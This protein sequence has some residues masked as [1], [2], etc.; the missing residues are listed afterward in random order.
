[1]KQKRL[2]KTYFAM[3][4]M[5]S[6]SIMPMFSEQTVQAATASKTVK[7][8]QTTLELTQGKTATLKML[9]TKSKAVFTS[10]NVKV[11]KVNKNTGRVAAKN[12][13]K[14]TITA[15]LKNG[16]KYT[17]KVTVT[18]GKVVLPTEDS[19]LIAGK[20]L[21]IT[22]DIKLTLPQNWDYELYEKS[23]KYI[24]YICLN[25]PDDEYKGCIYISG[26]P[27]TTE[28][29]FSMKSYAK[30]Q[31]SSLVTKTQED[32][33][34]VQGASYGTMSVQDQT[35]G[36]M[37][38]KAIKNETAEYETILIQKRGN[39]IFFYE[40]IGTSK[41]ERKEFASA[42]LFTLLSLDMDETT[43]IKIS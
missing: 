40:C 6:F 24:Q 37:T 29:S 9:N 13:G 16:K 17:C 8:S 36:V 18:F 3:L 27:Y 42:A 30:K 26:Q 7:L 28:G 1:M 19:S 35:I 10:S 21:A 22:D 43:T 4:C 5:L 23:S 25:L 20:E 14:A 2:K 12:A 33:Y 11:A 41:K 38:F 15:T 32:G 31:L 39:N 34:M